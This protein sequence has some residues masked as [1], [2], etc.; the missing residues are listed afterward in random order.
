MKDMN[1]GFDL[2]LLWVNLSEHC[3]KCHLVLGANSVQKFSVPC[4]KSSTWSTEYWKVGK[5]VFKTK[6]QR[7]WCVNPAQATLEMS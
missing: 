5:G 7:I 6:L 3:M 4:V 1:S 2:T